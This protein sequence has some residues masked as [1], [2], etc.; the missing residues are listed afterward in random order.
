MQISNILPLLTLFTTA[1]AGCY[2]EKGE[3]E[4]YWSKPDARARAV[5]AC[6]G[7]FKGTFGPKDTEAGHRKICVPAHPPPPNYGDRRQHYVFE[8]WHIGDGDREITGT[9]CLDGLRKE[10]NGCDYGGVSEYTNWKY[11]SDP[12]PGSCP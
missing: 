6:N 10:I 12:N 11:K 7:V 2:S 9:E 3:D 1:Y 4:A 8:I 5:D